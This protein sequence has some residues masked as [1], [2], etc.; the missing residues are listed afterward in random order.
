MN[1]AAIPTTTS[2]DSV[3]STATALRRFAARVRDAFKLVFPRFWLRRHVG[4]GANI[5]TYTPPNERLLLLEEARLALQTERFVEIGSHLGGSSVVLAEVLR[6]YGTKPDRRVYC[7]DTWMND[8]M[9]HGRQD[10]IGLFNAN[11]SRW[12]DHI[13]AVRGD[14]KTAALPFQGE[15]DLIFLDGDHSYAGTHADAERFAPMVRVG[16]RLVFHD[17]D[18]VE[19][20]RV[21]GELLARGNWIVSRS[22]GHIISLRREA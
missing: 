17:H 13:A 8:G 11:V 19:V 21:V 6:C 22:L 12:Q 5:F 7:V 18:R 1:N 10:T 4:A 9:S 16:G 2:P 3:P 20:A 14:S 15:C